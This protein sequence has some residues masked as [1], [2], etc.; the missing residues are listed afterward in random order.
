MALAEVS[1][2]LGSPVSIAEF[3]EATHAGGLAPVRW[4]TSSAPSENTDSP[5]PRCGMAHTAVRAIVSR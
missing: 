3:H 2:M 4:P 1:I 5:R